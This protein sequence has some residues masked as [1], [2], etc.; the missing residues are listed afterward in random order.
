MDSSLEI[1]VL[2]NFIERS[3]P[4]KPTFKENEVV[5][6]PAKWALE[7]VRVGYA[8]LTDKNPAADAAPPAEDEGPAPPAEEKKSDKATSKGK[9]KK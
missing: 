5:T 3:C 6:L 9:G 8:E 1:K 4:V 7:F 2:R